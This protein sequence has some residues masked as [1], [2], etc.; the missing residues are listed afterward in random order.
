MAACGLFKTTMR[1]D[2][3]N[4]TEIAPP[5]RKLYFPHIDLARAG[6]VTLVLIYHLIIQMGWTWFPSSG[7]LKVFRI[8][9]IGVDL[10]FVVSGFVISSSLIRN[11]ENFGL[12]GYIKPYLKN[13][14][15][16]VVPLYFLTSWC[17]LVLVEPQWFTRPPHQLWTNL[18]SH[19]FFVH[20]LSAEYAGALNGPAWSL[21]VEMQ[22]Y[23]LMAL[24]FKWLPMRRPFLVCFAFM[25]IAL[26]WRTG[27]CYTFD[28]S[29]DSSFD[30]YT[31]NTLFIRM[32]Q[33]PG[34]LDAFGLGCMMALIMR[35]HEHWFHK[36]LR[37][38]WK[39]SI[40]WFVTAMALS[41]VSWKILWSHSITYGNF[42]GVFLIFPV[43]VTFFKLLLALS[44]ACWIG[45]LVSLP[46]D[47][48]LI[49]ILSP[50]SYLGKISYGIYLWHMLVI[51]S[52]IKI[53]MAHPGQAAALVV[54]LT[55][56]IA[57][58][59]WHFFEQP[60]IRKYRDRPFAPRAN[61]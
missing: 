61:P 44:F 46:A 23:V 60:L 43:M 7:I 41:V 25:A 19:I 15:A 39:N 22:F 13:R 31:L 52:V 2:N 51:L 59:T 6:A 16:R 50:V 49:K 48:F 42:T 21:G 53:G 5:A 57:S 20:N 17:C 14:L 12:N 27:V 35:N 32:Q 34:T 33:L 37:T 38:G 36:Y 45:F 54:L 24:V 11:I 29:F 40:L 30:I 9:W 4:A 55:L 18:L 26:A 1:P 8:G 28:A 10:F 56:V 58:F 47:R 3:F